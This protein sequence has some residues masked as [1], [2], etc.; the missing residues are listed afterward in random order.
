MEIV[1]KIEKKQIEFS[2]EVY[3]LFHNNQDSGIKLGNYYK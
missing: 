3:I 1:D 2:S